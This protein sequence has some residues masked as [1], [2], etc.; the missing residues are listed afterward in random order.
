M[1]R[2]PYLLFLSLPLFAL[3]LKLLYLRNKKVLYAGHAIYSIHHYIFSFIILLLLM[4]FDTLEKTT[5]KG[6]GVI[7]AL[8]IVLWP[9]HLLLSMK[10][11]YGQGWW[12]T[13]GKMIL[14]NL[15]GLVTILVLFALFVLFSIFQL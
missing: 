14:L 5:W 8:L 6:F 9:V 1:H 4:V 10:K 7:T 2:L 3:S 11:F 13:I 15:M 12:K